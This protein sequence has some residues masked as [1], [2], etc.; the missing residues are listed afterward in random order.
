MTPLDVYC[1]KCLSD[2][3]Q[4]CTTATGNQCPPHAARVGLASAPGPCRQ[5]GAPRGLPCYQTSGAVRIYPHE[6][7]SAKAAE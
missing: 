3:G 4:D 1:T 7:R 6:A 5:C 2:V